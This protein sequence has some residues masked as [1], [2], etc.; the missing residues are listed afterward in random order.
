MPKLAAL[1]R[2]HQMILETCT[3][4]KE[5]CMDLKERSCRALPWAK[6]QSIV[7]FEHDG[8]NA[9]VTWHRTFRFLPSK[10][11]SAHNWPDCRLTQGMKNLLPFRL[12]FWRFETHSKLASIFFQ[13]SKNFVLVQALLVEV[14]EDEPCKPC[15]VKP[16]WSEF[17]RVCRHPPISLYYSSVVRRISNATIV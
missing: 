12:A 8:T 4:D 1:W 2:K 7:C 3:L 15:C 14:V 17:F 16:A 11:D 6:R 13:L 9:S 5:I 10:N